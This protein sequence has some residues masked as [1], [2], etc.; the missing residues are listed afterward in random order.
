[1]E[2]KRIFW[3]ETYGQNHFWGMKTFKVTFETAQKW[4]R[5]RLNAAP[6]LQHRIKFQVYA[7]IG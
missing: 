4:L 1:M 3:V 5:G 7:D 6:Q 2:N